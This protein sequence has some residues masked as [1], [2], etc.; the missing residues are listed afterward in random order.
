MKIEAA[1]AKVVHKSAQNVS[2]NYFLILPIWHKF[3][4]WPVA[5]C[6]ICQGVT[7]MIR[8]SKHDKVIYMDFCPVWEMNLLW[9]WFAL[10]LR[11]MKILYRHWVGEVS[12]G[13]DRR[14]NFLFSPKGSIFVPEVAAVAGQKKYYLCDITN[15]NKGSWF[16]MQNQRLH[17]SSES[18]GCVNTTFYL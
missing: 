7:H 9:L 16:I 12:W 11:S 6:I 3:P 15:S 18:K 4:K 1:A 2:A 14:T 13:R 10:L 5:D 17:L 8:T